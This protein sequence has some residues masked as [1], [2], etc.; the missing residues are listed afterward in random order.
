MYSLH[1]QSH[2]KLS[3]CV[4]HVSHSTRIA[5]RLNTCRQRCKVILGDKLTRILQEHTAISQQQQCP[6]AWCWSAPL[7]VT[8]CHPCPACVMSTW[9][10]SI[11]CRH[12]HAPPHSQ[13]YALQFHVRL[14]PCLDMI[15]IVAPWVTR[16]IYDAHCALHPQIACSCIIRYT[17]IIWCTVQ[18][19]CI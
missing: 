19:A 9:S 16:S 14:D 3:C 13:A 1:A 6:A 5:D 17:D 15:T 7:H 11:L 2:Y 10:H 8:S 12:G 18:Y 4:W